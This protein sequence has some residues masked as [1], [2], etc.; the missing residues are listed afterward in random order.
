ML[1]ILVMYIHMSLADLSECASSPCQNGGTCI[2]QV[3]A[4]TCSCSI[5]YQGSLCQTCKY[6]NRICIHTCISADSMFSTRLLS[7]LHVHIRIVRLLNAIKQSVI[8]YIR[9]KSLSQTCNCCAV[10]T[11]GSDSTPGPH[12]LQCLTQFWL[13]VGC[14]ESGTYAPASVGAGQIAFWDGLNV[15]AVRADM[16]DHYGRATG[17]DQTYMSRCFGP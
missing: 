9:P 16:T 2:D 7:H 4:F 10:A 13:E 15:A 11:C 8:L 14:L 3:N 12:P 6:Y 5:Q 1:Q 17:G